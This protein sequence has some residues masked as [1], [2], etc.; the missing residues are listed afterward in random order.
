MIERTVIRG[1]SELIGSWKMNCMFLR[2]V[3]NFRSGCDEMTSPLKSTSPSVGR[4]RA[5]RIRISV[6]LPEPDSPTMPS[7]SPLWIWNVTP[8]RACTPSF[9]PR[10]VRLPAYTRWTLRTSTTG[11]RSSTIAPNPP[12]RRVPAR[13]RPATGHHQG[14]HLN[15]LLRHPAAAVAKDAPA[16]E[17][18]SR[19]DTSRDGCQRLRLVAL[20]HVRALQEAE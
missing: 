15:A 1:S 8:R 10:D 5:A 2:R 16:R 17:M 13:D 19:R 20:A 12:V 6:D 18:T 7:L 11:T 3:F 9:A 4:S 14:R